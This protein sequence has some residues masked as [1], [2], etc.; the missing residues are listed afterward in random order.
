MSRLKPVTVTGDR[1]PAFASGLVVE[2]SRTT[3]SICRK[4]RA[5]ISESRERTVAVLIKLCAVFKQSSR[6][7]TGCEDKIV[8]DI[9]P[10]SAWLPSRLLNSAVK[11]VREIR[12]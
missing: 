7:Q 1:F 2:S 9:N 6:K 12:R 11:S 3:P 10:Q 4:F 5:W 8:G